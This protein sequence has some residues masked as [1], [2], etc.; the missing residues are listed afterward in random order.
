MEIYNHMKRLHILLAAVMM[1]AGVMAED[2][3]TTEQNN[4]GKQS[5]F[6]LGATG[7]MGYSGAFN[8]A[9]EPVIG[10]EFTDRFALGTG[11]GVMVVAGNGVTVAM[12]VV[13]PFVRLCAWHN[14]LVFIDF[15]ATAGLGF[16]RDLQMC[17]IG[18]R[19]SL[20]FRISEHCDIAA[21]IGLFGAQYTRADGWQPALGIT[22]TAA[23]LWFAYR[24]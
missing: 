15:K 2:N 5:A 20:R 1:A 11:I 12:G 6:F 24:F 23:G 17:Q 14:D 13:E 10:Y 18:V 9:F 3:T 19:P 4:Q 8:F 21:D 16:D 7:A 22:A